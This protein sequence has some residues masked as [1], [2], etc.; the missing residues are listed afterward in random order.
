MSATGLILTYHAVEVGPAPLCLAPSLFERHL[1]TLAAA[2]ARTLTVSELATGLR[3]GELPERAV[4]L[5]FDDGCASVA[6]NAAPLLAARGMCATVYCV[7][8]HLG[9]AN[10]WPTQPAKTP[11]LQLASA[12]DLSELA[13]AGF[14]IGSHGTAHA[15]LRATC[16]DV[17]HTEVVESRW[18]LEDALGT[19]VATFAYPYGLS[20]DPAARAVTAQTYSAACAGGLARVR[21]TGDPMALSRIDVHYLRRPSL[22]GSALEGRLD[23]YLGVRRLGARAR[24]LVRSDHAA[25]PG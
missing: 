6:H 8:G 17:I 23:A 2:G 18:R 24:R 10:D 4:A 1:D 21:T 9:K 11:R 7:A 14:E 25:P 3:R 20:P 16:E 13:A 5:T 12:S 22:L 19:E 15:P